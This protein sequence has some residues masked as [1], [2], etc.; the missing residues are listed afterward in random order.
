MDEAE[1]F[2][3]G[4]QVRVQVSGAKRRTASIVYVEAVE[5]E[6]YRLGL[7]WD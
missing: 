2:E 1:P 6:G 3:I 5:P 7:V 4:F